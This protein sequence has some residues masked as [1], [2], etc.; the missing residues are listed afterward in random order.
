[1]P[2]V[3]GRSHAR[4]AMAIGFV[5]ITVYQTLVLT[6]VTD[7]VIR[8]GIEADSYDMIWVNVAWGVS[9]VYSLFGAFW[10]IGRYG[11]RIT[12]ATGLAFFILGNLLLGLANDLPSTVVARFIEGIGKGLAIAVGRSALYKQFDRL[13]LVAIG[14]Y[15]V[16]AYA[17][18]PFTPLLTAYIN[19]WLS[20]RWIYWMNVPLALIGMV[21]VLNYLRPDRPAKPVR[22]SI[23][24]FALTMFVSWVVCLLFAFGWYRKWGGWSSNEFAI[25]V[26]LCLGL[27]VALL[28]WLRSG[29]S[30]DEH[31]KR[32]LRNRVYLL[33]MM[34]R[35]LLLLNLATVTAIVGQYFIELRGE[36]RVVAGWVLFPAAITMTATTLLT[37]YF[38]PRRFRHAWL[39][40]GVFGSA[41]CL[42]WLSFLDNFTPKEHVAVILAWWGAALGL[43]PP[44]FLTDEVE[45]IN[46]KDVMYAASLALVG[47]IVPLLTIPTMT[48][49][50]TKA[51]S[52]RALDV[53]R[54]NLSENR[55]AV[56]D[57]NSRIAD[58]YRQRGLA[59][60]D[61]QRTTSRILGSYVTIESVAVGFR[62]GFRF[63]SLIVLGLGL[64]IAI[65]LSRSARE[66]R[67]PPGAGYS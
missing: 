34:V 21:A 47:I 6:S 25:V 50:V 40:M 38:S 27:P 60:T 45:G 63:L 31:L 54:A 4:A 43:Y 30:P 48:S 2:A 19:D 66:L 61:L 58:H 18:R 65:P 32:L 8:K 15:G 23:D 41:A 51:W 42:W 67:A 5:L 52:D 46:P 44:V 62:Q 17:T 49:T 28:L 12:L 57:A 22:V 10:L 11:M 33:A 53:F 3:I 64:A 26:S 36:P 56:A 37:T 20:W 55:P 35:L 14:F 1:M 39:F 59:G 9:V 29:F 16:V 13:L 7:D 24:W